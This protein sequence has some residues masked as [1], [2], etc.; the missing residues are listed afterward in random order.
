METSRVRPVR[1]ISSMQIRMAS[2]VGHGSLFLRHRG[3][4]PAHG[5]SQYLQRRGGL[6][7]G[8]VG[9]PSRRAQPPVPLRGRYG[10]CLLGHSL[11]QCR[12]R[13]A[14]ERCF[15]PAR[16]LLPFGYRGCGRTRGWHG[17]SQYPADAGSSG[18]LTGAYKDTWNV[19][20]GSDGLSTSV[21]SSIANAWSPGLR[22]PRSTASLLPRM[23]SLSATSAIWSAN[24]SRPP[25]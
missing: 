2:C 8:P 24:G 5:D 18:H 13:N 10:L 20:A 22:N 7:G 19:G 16:C 9:E 6:P 14:G 17:Q 21:A 3:I 23:P 4:R 11:A 25:T 12:F 15:R 1:N